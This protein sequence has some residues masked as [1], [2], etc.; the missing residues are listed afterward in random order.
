MKWWCGALKNKLKPQNKKVF[1][2]NWIN[3]NN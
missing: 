3:L 2:N 1:D